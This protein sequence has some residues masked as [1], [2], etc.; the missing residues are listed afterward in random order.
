MAFQANT[1]LTT[2]ALPFFA[3]FIGQLIF[4]FT[5]T[6]TANTVTVVNASSINSNALLPA[7]NDGLTVAAL[8]TGLGHI[9]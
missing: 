5:H 3:E 8:A 1:M 2:V 4:A 7:T 6:S 9:R